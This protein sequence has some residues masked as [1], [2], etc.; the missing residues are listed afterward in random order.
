[1]S[2]SMLDAALAYASLGWHVFP[3]QP[4]GKIP[5]TEKGQNDSTTDPETIRR[6]WRQWPNANIG[7]HL[8]K[9]GLCALDVDPRNG[10]STDDLPAWPDT[11]EAATGGGGQHILFRV[12]PDAH[13]PGKLRPGLD[14]KRRGY[15]VVEPS[16]HPSGGAYRFLDWD[17]ADGPPEI[18]PAPDWL[19]SK[20]INGHDRAPSTDDKFDVRRAVREI[21]QS[22]RYHDNLIRLAAHFMVAGMKV[23]DVVAV[24]RGFMEAVRV[25][26][27]RWR[28]RYDA[29]PKAV[30]SAAEKFIAEGPA[31][32]RLQEQ[33]ITEFISNVE[34][35]EY[36]WDGILQ[37]GSFYAFT[38][39]TGSG[40]T[41]LA[42]TLAVS[43]ALG[44]SFAGRP[45]ARGKV[46][47]VAGENPNDVRIRLHAILEQWRIEPGELS[48]YL[49]FVD[50]SF[51]L[52][53]R[54]ADFLTLVE[55]SA[56]S[57]VI[58]DTDQA[59]SGSEEENDNAERVAHAKRAR[60]IT[61][62]SSRPCV[63]D[64]CHPNAAAGKGHLRP[65]GASGF[66][67][68]IDG[69]AG[70]WRDEGTGI[71]EFFRTGKYRGPDF[72]PIE[73]ELEQVSCSTVTDAQGRP[74]TAVVAKPLGH[75]ELVELDA[76]GLER[77]AKLVEDISQFPNASV[78]ERAGRLQ[79]G[80]SSVARAL[81][82]LVKSGIAAESI[83]GHELT[84]KGKKWLAAR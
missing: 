24:L 1:M 59:L 46:M 84:A 8:E 42:L 66:L 78:R 49:T 69:N 9:S 11:L 29:I 80:K 7:F 60:L 43:I 30:R 83:D 74:M 53:D 19:I 50:Q 4:R 21:L 71:V 73:F 68:E 65:R 26:D 75:A 15:I 54:Q 23:P 37:S 81:M 47:Y 39:Q 52:L 34:T 2:G 3:L 58:L 79:T 38:G 55:E 14:L 57:L 22:E 77:R 27:D 45:T 36:L 40:K 61:R 82:D 31:A 35:P 13:I 32:D 28:D 20:P 64:L 62:V 51:T 33:S 63:V 44:R 12:A 10:G 41:A 67:A 16:I 70:V 72:D 56:P 48:G 18:A 25:Q 6:W 17:P 5:M 76:Q